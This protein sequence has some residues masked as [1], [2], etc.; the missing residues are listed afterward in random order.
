MTTT[1]IPVTQP[2]LPPLEDFLPYLERIWES[3]ILT[4]GGRFHVELERALCEY[5]D[6]EHIALFMNGT[7]ALISALQALRVTDEV[8]TTPFSFI[9]TAHAIHWNRATPVFVDIDPVTLNIDA[10]R[11]ERAITPRTTAILPV[12][13]Y[14]N[15]CDVDAIRQIADANGLKVIY[16]AAHAFAVRRQGSSLLREGD[17]SVL[18]FHATKVFNTF[19]GG[20]IVCHDRT[21]KLRI[22]SLK[23]FSLSDDIAVVEP[24]LNGK[25]SEFQAAF[26]LLQLRTVAL[27]IEKRKRVDAL[28]REGLAGVEGIEVIGRL[29]DVDPNFSYFPIL[30]KPS[31]PLT[32][33]QLF[34]RLGERGIVAR[35]YFFPLISDFAAYRDLPS[36][37]SANLPVATRI[38]REVL[39]LPIF[40]HLDESTV[41]RIIDDVA[42]V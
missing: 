18:S 22:D 42:R 5:L 9:A 10:G 12:H 37:Q 20:A 36:A 6:V 39:C 23:N 28:Y 33:D 17:L 29:V 40:P 35:R 38:A 27:A 30:V 3:R 11:I 4:N 25:M 15:P 19:E 7:I 1:P 2:D 32:R 26:G 34:Q 24:G 14:G 16:D 8:I 31:Y 13:C 21:M 41:R